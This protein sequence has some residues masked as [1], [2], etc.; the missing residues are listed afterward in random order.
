VQMGRHC[1]RSHLGRLN[2][3]DFYG[4]WGSVAQPKQI[5]KLIDDIKNATTSDATYHS[6][7]R[8]DK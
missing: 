1:R 6:G 7:N 8:I 4:F 3:P 5:D 2:F